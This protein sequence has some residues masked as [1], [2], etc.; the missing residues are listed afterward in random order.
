MAKYKHRYNGLVEA[1]DH[2]TIFAKWEDGDGANFNR[3]REYT[4]LNR[5]SQPTIGQAKME[6]LATETLWE[7]IREFVSIKN[8]SPIVVQLLI[9]MEKLRKPVYYMISNNFHSFILPT[10]DGIL[11]KEVIFCAKEQSNCFMKGSLCT[12]GVDNV[13]VDKEN[14]RR[15]TEK[16]IDYFQKNTFMFLIDEPKNISDIR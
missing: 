3:W 10:K 14:I 2:K 11:K 5:V 13:F 12:A 1:V 4:G 6:N 15:L 7:S 8:E 9:K 16:E